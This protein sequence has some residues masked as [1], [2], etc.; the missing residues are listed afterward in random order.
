MVGRWFVCDLFYVEINI[1][2]KTNLSRRFFGIDRFMVL[3][4]GFINVVYGGAINTIYKLVIPG[5]W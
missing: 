4:N 5:F 1:Y 3:I 2:K